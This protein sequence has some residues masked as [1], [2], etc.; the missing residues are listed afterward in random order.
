M[1]LYD[2]L[3]GGVSGNIDLDNR[4]VVKN[5]DGSISTVRS[6]S[7][8]I[9]GK[10]VLLPTIDDSGRTLT[11]EEA[12]DLY[13]KTGK[14]LGMFQTPEEATSYAKWLH[15]DQ[16]RKYA[17]EPPLGGPV[18]RLGEAYGAP[19]P[20]TPPATGLGSQGQVQGISYP[21]PPPD[22]RRLWPLLKSLREGMLGAPVGSEFYTG[23]PGMEEFGGVPSIR[24]RRW[25]D[26][27]I[28]AEQGMMV[29]SPTAYHASRFPLEGPIKE[30]TH[31]GSKKAA[32]ERLYDTV[33]GRAPYQ[34]EGFLYKVDIKP[35]KQY[36]PGGRKLSELDAEERTQLFTLNALKRE[37]KQL[38]EQGFD[39]VPYIN[40]IEGRGTTSYMVLDPEIVSILS[41]EKINVGKLKRALR[42]DTM[43]MMNPP[44]SKWGKE[45]PP[46]PG[47]QEMPP[48]KGKIAEGPSKEER[49]A[50]LVSEGRMSEGMV[51]AIKDPQSGKVYTGDFHNM[52]A[53]SQKKNPE[54]Y[55]RLWKA[56]ESERDKP[57]KLVG[58]I[59]DA[60]EFMTRKEADAYFGAGEAGSLMAKTGRKT[61]EPGGGAV[62]NYV[63]TGERELA[64]LP[65]EKLALSGFTDIE[66]GAE[67]AIRHRF[68]K[69]LDEEG[70]AYIRW[71]HR[72][73]NKMS[74][75]PN[76]KTGLSLDMSTSCCNRGG[77]KGAC[78]Y[79][80][81][82]QPRIG[83]DLGYKKY[84]TQR[85][86]IV[87]TPYPLEF[88]TGPIAQMP[89]SLVR[90][91]NRDGGLR[92]MS[93]SDFIPEHEPMW[94][95]ALA[96]AE[97]KG[98]IIKAITKD[99]R[100][101]QKFGSHPNM[102][103][104]IS[105]D[106]LPRSMSNA[107]TIEQALALKGGRPNIKIRS[108]ALN[109]AQARAQY[110]DPRIDVVTL[111]HGPVGDELLEIVMEQNRELVERIGVDRLKKELATWENMS[112]KSAIHKELTAAGKLE[113]NPR[114]C[115]GGGKCSRDATK[116]GFGM[117]QLGML[118][119]GVSIWD[120]EGEEE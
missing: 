93:F 52:I 62:Y 35:K 23:V 95:N 43:S 80:Y 70:R 112:S 67:S 86:K 53:E 72:N 39:V 91:L 111:Y 12:V 33:E 69:D 103:I 116:C 14:H 32:M 84:I 90:E 106:Q 55:G 87:E 102:R 57:S 120:A 56:L 42:N 44:P 61:Y 115:C 29:M 26:P 59:N 31:F 10:E 68:G 75:H 47:V 58:F 28:M 110:A 51:A 89:D 76:S 21:P 13:R 11:T 64:G 77:K 45:I 22:N 92:G 20:L 97:S 94:R 113:G 48:I 78:V 107:M 65:G 40:A 25:F 4:P 114:V 36:K 3:Y 98:L 85:K 24:G 16:A 108:V 88:G 37:R 7:V 38:R 50:Q 5:P 54:V 60:G 104:N 66:K 46:Q 79:C 82:E 105:I 117:G 81:V 49:W 18:G 9:D 8:N 63:G 34:K 74:I 99:K 1:N 96:E 27:E 83:L 73:R 41:E 101:V 100:F 71:V 6:I 17:P 30:G 109:E 19:P 15:E 118:I 119:A 2:L